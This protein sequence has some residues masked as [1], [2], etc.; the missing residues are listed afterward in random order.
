MTQQTAQPASSTAD[1]TS[2][3]AADV[4]AGYAEALSSAP[5]LGYLVLYSVFDGRV[6]PAD[7]SDWFDELGLDK[8][9][10][11]PALRADGAFDVAARNTKDSYEIP[12][13]TAAAQP[14]GARRTSKPSARASSQRTATLMIRP[15]RRDDDKIVMHLV[16]EVRD[17]GKA[18]LSYTENAAEI[19]F[20]RHRWPGAATGAGNMQITANLDSVPSREHEKVSALLDAL[21]HGFDRHCRYLTGD[22]IR[23]MLHAYIE[24]M[25]AIKVRPSGGVYFLHSSHAPT[26]DAL[27]TLLSR[28]GAGSGLYKIPLPDEGEMREMV[29]EAWRRE[30]REDLQKLS[31]DIAEA[32]T[33]AG[34]GTPATT[35]ALERLHA[36]F[37]QLVQQAGEHGRQLGADLDEMNAAMALAGTQ[38]V[39]LLTQA[40]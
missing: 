26:L 29:I 37:T 2:G 24:S 28:F 15:V 34:R 39:T 10:L 13:R 6:S 18:R 17:S 9:L 4:L 11:P 35:S 5:L 23:A 12:A 20:T 8:S 38:I 19:T 22:K 7:L 33:A 1:L 14:R 32:Q 31:A 40:G 21:R 30:Q 16:R 25:T 36:R 3:T 27:R